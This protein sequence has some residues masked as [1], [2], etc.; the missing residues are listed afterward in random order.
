MKMRHSPDVEDSAHAVC[1]PGSG[2]YRMAGIPL[3][4]AQI[5]AQLPPKGH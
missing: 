5:A 1:V 4:D 3:L 2:D